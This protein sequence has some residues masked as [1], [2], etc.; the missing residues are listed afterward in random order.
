MSLKLRVVLDFLFIRS[1][2]K[3]PFLSGER[4]CIFT[5]I[6][7]MSFLHEMVGGFE[8]NFPARAVQSSW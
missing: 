5:A 1:V 2:P 8:M 4:E 6:V 7:I 3:V